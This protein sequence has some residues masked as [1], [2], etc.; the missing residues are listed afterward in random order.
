MHARLLRDEGPLHHDGGL[1]RCEPED[2]DVCHLQRREQRR[3]HVLLHRELGLRFG[4]LH[5]PGRDRAGCVRAGCVV[6]SGWQPNCA[7]MQDGIGAR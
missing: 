1:L 6:M 4:V 3:L 5:D 7:T 2:R